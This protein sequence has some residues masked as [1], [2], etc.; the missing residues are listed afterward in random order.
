M[1]KLLQEQEQLRKQRLE[2]LD[3]VNILLNLSGQS[4]NAALLVC[5]EKL[6]DN[7]NKMRGVRYDHATYLKAKLQK[8]AP[9]SVAEKPKQNATK[10]KAKQSLLKERRLRR[11]W[12]VIYQIKQLKITKL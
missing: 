9:K 5:G 11:K 8:P 2:I 3:E 7:T 12:L 10:S 6:I 1:Q 4:V